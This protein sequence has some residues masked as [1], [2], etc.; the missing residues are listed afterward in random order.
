[1]LSALKSFGRSLLPRP[2][3]RRYRAARVTRIVSR[4]T[5][6]VVEHLYGGSKLRVS[7]EDPLAEGWYDHDW[8]ELDEI[9]LLRRHRLR[10]GAVVFDLGA[11][12]A[13]VAL[14]LAR[15]VGP[16]G[17]VIAVEA[18][19]HNVAVAK[20]NAALNEARNLSIVWAAVSDRPGE[21]LFTVELNGRVDPGNPWGKIRVPAVRIDDLLRAY[22]QPDV[23]WLDV[24]GHEAHALRGAAE[25]IQRCCDVYVEVHAGCGLEIS[26]GTVAEII[27]LLPDRRLLVAEAT[28]SGQK[29]SWYPMTQEISGRTH[30]VALK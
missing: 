30:L 12:Q 26:G 4:Y 15:I 14:M 10:E 28:P 16:T 2:V 24:E 3:Y 29:L 5:P 1:M 13:V 6:R 21:L 20:R 11:H 27:E 23:L 8:P 17:R 18:E 25:T 7:L 22:G 19:P 9:A